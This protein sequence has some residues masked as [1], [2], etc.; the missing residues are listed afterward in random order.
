MVGLPARRIG[1]AGMKALVAKQRLLLLLCLMTALRVSSIG[2]QAGPMPRRS[3]AASTRIKA[4]IMRLIFRCL[5]T[6]ILAI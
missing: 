4:V 1:A 6:V 5:I 2:R 3:G